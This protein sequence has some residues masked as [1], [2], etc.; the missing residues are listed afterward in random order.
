MGRRKIIAAS[1]AQA[2]NAGR[3]SVEFASQPKD[4]NAHRRLNEARCG[5]PEMT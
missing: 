2:A 3:E 5:A 4:D 1:S